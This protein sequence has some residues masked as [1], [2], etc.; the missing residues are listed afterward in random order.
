MQCFRVEGVKLPTGYYFGA[1]AATGIVFNS[2]LTF[3]Q[4]RRKRTVI[5]EIENFDKFKIF[6]GDLSDAHDII[7]MKLFELDGPENPQ[8]NL[9]DR[10]KIEPSSTVFE[11][12]RDHVEDPK[13][14]SMSGKK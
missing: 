8:A 4:M 12:P 13:S 14:S 9:E 5:F 6:E 3:Q 11:P 10:S 7:T 1:S 2:K